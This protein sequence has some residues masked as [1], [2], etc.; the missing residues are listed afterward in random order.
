MMRRS[1]GILGI[2]VLSLLSRLWWRAEEPSEAERADSAPTT[3]VEAASAAEV[4]REAL[5]P[6]VEGSEA[7][8]QP[9]HS[10]LLVY[11]LNGER[12]CP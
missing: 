12:H 4:L 3:Q 11:A 5:P 10:G 2:L 6:E 1:V 9:H 7:P 8:A